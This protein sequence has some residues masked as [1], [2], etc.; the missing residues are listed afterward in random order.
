[1]RHVRGTESTKRSIQKLKKRQAE[2]LNKPASIVLAISIGGVQFLNP[3]TNVSQPIS[4][5]VI[6]FLLPVRLDSSLQIPITW[7]LLNQSF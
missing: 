6:F 1:M 4:N 2:D 7:A 5:Q 3:V